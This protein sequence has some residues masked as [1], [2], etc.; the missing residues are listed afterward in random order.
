MKTANMNT[1][2]T[3]FD[4]EIF[5]KLMNKANVSSKHFNGMTMYKGKEIEAKSEILN[6]LYEYGTVLD[7][8]IIQNETSLLVEFCGDSGIWTEWCHI[9]ECKNYN[10]LY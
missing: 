2:E 3:N 10:K 8:T 5:H 4:R 7:F 9:T 1:T 6:G